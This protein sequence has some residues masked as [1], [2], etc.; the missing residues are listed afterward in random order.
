MKALRTAKPVEKPTY[1]IPE[2]ARLLGIGV[3]QTREAVKNGQ[4]PSIKIND[5]D[6]ILG[7]PL[8]RLLNG[9]AAK[10]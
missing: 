8:H 7:S 6:R 4:I 10:P 2:G 5:R 1:S 9:G 3:K